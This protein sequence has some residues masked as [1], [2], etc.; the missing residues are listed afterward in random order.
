MNGPTQDVRQVG[1]R[2]P[3]AFESIVRRAVAADPDLRRSAGQSARAA[4]DLLRILWTR[5]PNLAEI[6]ERKDFV[7]LSNPVFAQDSAIWR[8]DHQ[9]AGALPNLSS[10]A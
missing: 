3:E 2:E 7:T 5:S 6:A 4:F 1:G 8:S 10:V 9:P